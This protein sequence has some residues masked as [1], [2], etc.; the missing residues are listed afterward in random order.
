MEYTR[1]TRNVPESHMQIVQILNQ[2]GFFKPTFYPKHILF[3]LLQI[4]N[5]KYKLCKKSK[6]KTHKKH[7]HHVASLIPFITKMSPIFTYF[8]NKSTLKRAQNAIKSIFTKKKTACVQCKHIT[9]AFKKYTR[10][11]RHAHDILHVCL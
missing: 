2:A 1:A 6:K 9:Q 5:K 3:S 4:Y 10:T 11:T 7:H 8:T